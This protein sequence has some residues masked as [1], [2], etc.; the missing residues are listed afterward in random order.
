MP[1]HVF[2]PVY[3]G[4]VGTCRQKACYYSLVAR[5]IKFP[6]AIFSI[7]FFFVH[8]VFPRTITLA[9]IFLYRTSAHYKSDALLRTARASCSTP[10][11]AYI[12]LINR[13]TNR[14]PVVRFTTLRPDHPSARLADSAVINFSI[15]VVII[16][17]MAD[18]FWP[19]TSGDIHLK[20]Y[21]ISA[22]YFCQR[23]VYLCLGLQYCMQDNYS[24]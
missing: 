24:L 7:C 2:W 13:N 16:N 9:Y 10:A 4:A 1:Q 17:S 22:Y 21:F 8:I 12:T 6:G 18:N 15:T 3:C 5:P 20:I 23:A 11:S 14:R 19:N